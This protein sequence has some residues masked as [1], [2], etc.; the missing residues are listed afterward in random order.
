MKTIL[1]TGATGL[2]GKYFLDKTPPG[3]KVIGTYNNNLKAKKKFFI[4]LDITSKRKANLLINSVNPDIVVHAA[5]LGSVDYCEL[6]KKEASDVNVKGTINVVEACRLAKARL[7]FIS[8]NAVYDGEN[9]TYSEDSPRKPLD[10]YGRTKVKGEN[11]VVTSGL[12]FNIVRL[13]TMYGWPPPS[14]RSNPVDWIIDELLNKRKINVVDDI[15]NN[16]LYA[17]SASGVL[18]K[19]IE[20]G[21]INESYNVSGRDCIT[22]FELAVKIAEVFNLDSALVNPVKS[23][24]F[25]NIAPRP[26]N[27]CFNTEKIEKDFKIKPLGITEGLNLMK[28]EGS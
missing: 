11:V 14:G 12:P 16:H 9:P 27:T 3:Y 1:F 5:S 20:R 24:F 23:D 28:N 17:G 7:I 26:K 25:K 6:H 21:E 10:E 18:W 15:Y 22:R 8:S 4:K 13:M 2:L 19:I